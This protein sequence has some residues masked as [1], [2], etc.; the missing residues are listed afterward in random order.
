[1]LWPNDFGQATGVIDDDRKSVPWPGGHGPNDSGLAR[2]DDDVDL[3]EDF[4]AAA[5][6]LSH[7]TNVPW[8]HGWKTGVGV[9]ETLF[10]DTC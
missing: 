5:A 7:D 9:A 4:G 10:A 8:P 1:M 2:G 6:D 3:R